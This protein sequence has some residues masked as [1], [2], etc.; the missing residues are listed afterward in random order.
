MAIYGL[1]KKCMYRVQT[2]QENKSTTASYLD[3]KLDEACGVII[4]GVI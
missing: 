1:H 4:D 3:F 2:Q